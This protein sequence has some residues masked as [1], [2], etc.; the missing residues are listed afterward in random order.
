MIEHELRSLGIRDEAVL[1]AMRKVPREEFV[2]EGLREFAYRNTP[3]PIESGQTISQP[4]IVASMT[5]ALALTPDSRVLE[6]GTGSGYSAAVR[7]QLAREVFT[8][9]RHRELALTAQERLRRLGYD[10]VHVLHADGTRGWPEKAPFDGIVVTTGSP[11]V[12]RPLLEQLREGGRLVIPAG[13]T[14]DSQRVVR[15]VRRDGEFEYEPL[16]AVRFVPLSHL[17]LA[18]YLRSP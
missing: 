11:D 4:L 9:E 17:Q 18:P 7:S 16:T 6:I 10:N 3:L 15:V 1:H 5:E 8:V 13:E 2:S 14:R 12:P